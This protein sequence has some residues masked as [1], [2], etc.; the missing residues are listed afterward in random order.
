MAPWAHERESSA[1]LDGR[2]TK[3]EEQQAHQPTFLNLKYDLLSPILQAK[4]HSTRPIRIQ[5]AHA[6]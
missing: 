2:L 4:S 3:R 6:E 1:L 5:N